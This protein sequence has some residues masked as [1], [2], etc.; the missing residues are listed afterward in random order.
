[1]ATALQVP[2]QWLVR[3][4]LVG[5][6]MPWAEGGKVLVVP[7]DGSHW[8]SMK[9]LVRE[10]HS[11]G[12]QAVVLAPEVSLQIRGDDF[13]T[14]KSFAFPYTQEEFNNFLSEGSFIIE[15]QNILET[16]LTIMPS[17][18]KFSELY[19]KSCVQML[20]NSTL[21]SQL[22]ASS[23]DVVLT[24][25]VFPCGAVLAQY[26][27]IP[28]V[29]FLRGIPCGLDFEGT[30]CPHPFSYI[31]QMFTTHSDHMT[32]LQRV[33]NMLYPVG[34]KLFCHMVFSPYASFASELL[35]KEVSVVDFLSHASVWLMRWD[36]VLEYPRPIMPNMVFIGGINCMRRK[37]LSQVCIG[38]SVQSVSQQKLLSSA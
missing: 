34:L 12:H 2:W 17:F 23:F 25:P 3:L 37:P 7:M 18:K 36:F 28:T 10:L 27:S 19:E 38:A 13:F 5:C 30:Q 16:F 1:M 22:N 29:F 11:R 14:L 24:D 20:R 31:P 33:K 9:D 35:Q 15:T 32:F 6:V 4:L 21:I 8:L 26:L